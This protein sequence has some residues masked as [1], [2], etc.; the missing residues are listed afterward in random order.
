MVGKA[1]RNYLFTIGKTSFQENQKGDC[2][3]WRLGAILR[4]CDKAEP[5][6]T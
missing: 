3:Q 2:E 4:C 5:E 6:K 1:K